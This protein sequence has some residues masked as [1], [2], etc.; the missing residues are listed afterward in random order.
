MSYVF[1]TKNRSLTLLG[2]LKTY[3]LRKDLTTSS[4]HVSKLLLNV[5]KRRK[6]LIRNILQRLMR[7][8]NA[9][10]VDVNNHN[11]FNLPVFRAAYLD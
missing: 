10:P 4:H 8:K 7:G 5:L 6:N 9:P 11:A 1:I 3:P 2:L